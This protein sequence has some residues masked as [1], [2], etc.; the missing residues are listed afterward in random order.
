MCVCV[1]LHVMVTHHHIT[2][3]GIVH[4][5]SMFEEGHQLSFHHSLNHVIGS[6]AIRPHN[7]GKDLI[8]TERQARSVWVGSPSRLH[9]AW[10]PHPASK[11]GI[12]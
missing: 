3:I 5:Y 8:E 1:D 4:I 7:L 12:Q 10:S 6:H 2:S 9:L 11:L